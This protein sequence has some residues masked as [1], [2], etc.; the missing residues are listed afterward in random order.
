LENF[1]FSR[2]VDVRLDFVASLAAQLAHKG[3]KHAENIEIVA[4]FRRLSGNRL[5]EGTSRVLDRRQSVGDDKCSD[6][7]AGDHDIFPRLPDNG[8]V[9]ALSRVAAK[10]TTQCNDETNEETQAL[11]SQLEQ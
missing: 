4:L 6:R 7:R 11:G 3:I 8:H 2:I 1:G 9:A 5:D 10:D